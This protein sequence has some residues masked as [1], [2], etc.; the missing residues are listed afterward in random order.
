MPNKESHKTLLSIVVPVSKIAGKSEFLKSWIFEVDYN[1][2]EVLLVHDVQDDQTSSEIHSII[3]SAPNVKIF[4]RQVNSPGAARNTGIENASGKYITFWDADDYPDYQEYVHESLRLDSLNGDCSILN[5]ETEI[6]PL[7]YMGVLHENNLLLVA[8]NP[9]IWRWIFRRESLSGINFPNLRMAEDQVFLAR[10]LAHQRKIIFSER[11]SYRYMRSGPHQLTRNPDALVDLI[12]SAYFTSELIKNSQNLSFTFILFMRQ[13]LTGIK[14]G[15]LPVK[16]KLF[17]H[18]IRVILISPK[19]FQAVTFAYFKFYKSSKQMRDDLNPEIL[20]SLTGGLGNQLFQLAAGLYKGQLSPLKIEWDLGKPRKNSQGFPEIKSFKLP[21]IIGFDNIR[22]NSWI[23]SKAFGYLLRTGFS[24]N[25]FESYQL[26]KTTS[27]FAGQVLFFFRFRFYRKLNISNDIGYS[28]F[29]IQ[30]RSH[31]IGYFQSYVWTQRKDV[32]E[33][34]KNLSIGDFPEYRKF[35]ELSNIEKP[36][37]VHIRLTDYLEEELLGIPNLK[38]YE[39]AIGNQLKSGRYNKIWAFS[40]DPEQATN[41]LKGLDSNLIRWIPK[42][43]DSDLNSFELMRLGHG[44]VI[45]NSTFSWWAARLS[46]SSQPVVIYPKPWFRSMKE[47][48]KLIP[49]EWVPE[50]SGW[51]ID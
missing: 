24:P 1:L 5:F 11:V 16:Y 9:G 48:N 45:A 47:P 39:N 3:A 4:E 46:H 43:G 13:C 27:K 12:E 41:W 28:D 51:G 26:Y 40:D 25:K 37:V 38:Y 33:F 10:Y 20:V 19:Q 17:V 30:K 2:V 49:P 15:N 14:K 31:L 50:N 42:I 22:K 34:L 29:D 35:I 36:L 7:N 8:F 18:L 32:F 6:I 21:A 23:Y 44:Y